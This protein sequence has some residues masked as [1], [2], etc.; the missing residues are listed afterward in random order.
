VGLQ[1][2]KGSCLADLLLPI[3]IEISPLLLTQIKGN[4]KI[5]PSEFSD[6]GITQDINIETKIYLLGIYYQ[7]V[8]K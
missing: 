4:K 3:K 6:F 7:F 2:N 1:C 5:L 8:S